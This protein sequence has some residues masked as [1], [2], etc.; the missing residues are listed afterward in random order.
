MTT[1]IL[2]EPDAIRLRKLEAFR[3]SGIYVM[4]AFILFIMVGFFWWRST[5]YEEDIFIPA[6]ATVSL[7]VCYIAAISVNSA[8]FWRLVRTKDE[9]WVNAYYDALDDADY[10]VDKDIES[11]WRYRLA[12]LREAILCIII[13]VTAV[14]S[15]S[16]F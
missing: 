9:K 12:V 6:V 3:D 1:S 2:K 4:T 8:L 10:G 15:S 16:I 5:E 14:I 7:A 13:L 11:S